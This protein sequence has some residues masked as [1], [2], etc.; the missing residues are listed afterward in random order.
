MTRPR[1][2]PIVRLDYIVRM[3]CFP[4]LIAI[5]YS[6]FHAS[7][8]DNA[9]VIVLLLLWGLV[10][11]QLAYLHARYSRDSKRAE[12]WNLFVDSVLVGAWAAGMHF[13]LWPSIMFV[14]G[15][16]LGNLGV[17]GFRLG[18]RGVIGLALGVLAGGWLTGFAMDLQAP[19]LPTAASIVGIFLISSVFALHS[20]LQSKRFVHNRKLLEAQNLQIEEKNDQL[21]QAKDEAD[22]ANRSKSLFLANMSH[23]LRTPLNAIIGYSEL[24]EEEAREDGE[25]HLVPDLEKIH[26]AGKHLLGLINEVLDLSKIEAGKMEVHLEDVDVSAVLE[27]VLATVRPLAEKSDNRLTLDAPAP[28]WM[29]TDVTKL[30]Q[31]LFNLLGNA[32]KFTSDGEI[33]LRARREALESGESMVF[34]VEDTGIGMTAEQQAGLFQPFAQADS[35]TTRQY[36]GTGLGLAVSRHC[37]QLL[38]GDID[39]HSTP[40]A[41][42]TFTI[43][44]PLEAPE[45]LSAATAG[46][47][48]DADRTA[49]SGEPPGGPVVLVVDDDAAGTELIERVLA[50]QGLRVESASNGSGGLQRARELRP[51]VILLDVRMPGTDGWN[52]LAQLKADPQ[53]AP[54]PVVMISV[55]GQ[56][57]LGLALGAADY[58][59]KPVANDALVHTVRRHLGDAAAEQPILVIDDDATTRTMLRRQLERAGW[60]VIEA[61][62]GVEGMDR[63][64]DS[65]PALVLLDLVMPRMDGF[66]FLDELRG[67]PDALTLPVIVLTSKD[68]THAERS[69]LSA[70]AGKV[71]AKGRYTSDQLEEE[72]RRALDD[73]RMRGLVRVAG[74]SPE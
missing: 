34:E 62:D 74:E 50:G 58:L 47:A 20:Y 19:P 33:T 41:G 65:A 8:R 5:F 70:R 57:T 4:L 46:A 17:G 18:V 28:G 42:T 7:G 63:L 13:S 14:T 51:A 12:H 2:H 48:T 3:T 40:G 38:G 1:L 16:N 35:S 44:I 36:G 55:T 61:A 21:A 22:A 67:R 73:P 53:L 49:R 6:V 24:L 64:G 9:G 68:L 69:E 54:I 10:W 31:M 39:L 26:S 30:R 66:A 72:V 23:E 56:R 59:V 15:V 25:E 27:D 43:R 29:Q 60:R 45:T 52:V 32:A 71:I 37:A 11:P